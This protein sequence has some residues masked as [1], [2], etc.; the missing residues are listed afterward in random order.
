MKMDLKSWKM[1]LMTLS[2][3]P[4]TLKELSFT[5][6][7]KCVF[8]NHSKVGSV[9]EKSHWTPLLTPVALW[10]PKLK[11]GIF[12]KI[13][14]LIYIVG[15]FNTNRMPY[16]WAGYEIF[17]RKKMCLISIQ[18]RFYHPVVPAHCF[19]PDVSMRC[20]AKTKNSKNWC[21]WRHFRL[22]G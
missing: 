22:M 11:P 20:T 19:F 13:L 14:K 16:R 7:R 12:L 6:K 1:H 9:T 15:N 2:M 8:I 21:F 5:K 3:T 4:T 10:R 17:F 18:N